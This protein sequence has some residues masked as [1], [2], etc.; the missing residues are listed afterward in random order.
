MPNRSN[1]PQYYSRGPVVTI[2]GEA[3][4]PADSGFRGRSE[5]NQQSSDPQYNPYRSI[6]PVGPA[7]GFFNNSIPPIGP[8]NGFGSNQNNYIYGTAINPMPVIAGAP[9]LLGGYYYGNYCD[10]AVPSYTYPSVYSTYAGFPRFLFNPTVIVVSQ[11]YSPVYVSAYLPFN[12]PTYSVT[13][14]QTNYYFASENQARDLEA[15]GDQAAEAR[16]NAYSYDSYQAA[17]ADIARAWTN[18][19]SSLLRRHLRDSD[20]R[21]SVFLNNKYSYSIASGDFLQIT[22]DA[23]NSL[24]TVSFEFT[25]LRKAKNGDVTAFGKHVYRTADASANAGNDSG[26]ETVPFDQ[27]GSLSKNSPTDDEPTGPIREAA[28]TVYVS[29]TLRHGEGQW[30]LIATDSSAQS[31]TASE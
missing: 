6:A 10:A 4:G 21:L 30:Y 9:P 31:L 14:N 16:R 20:T 23:L 3:A 29:Y 17:F 11:P 18:G 22:R 5:W 24:N 26:G 13:Y 28:K 8:G 25:R 7:N 2:P 19:D 12:P 1:S 27:S 15:G